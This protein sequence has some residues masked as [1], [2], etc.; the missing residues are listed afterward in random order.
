MTKMRFTRPAMLYETGDA[1]L[2]SAKARMFC[3]K[4]T[5]PLK[6]NGA[7]SDED[8]ALRKVDNS[9]NR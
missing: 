1:T 3:P 9:P 7:A 6:I 2:N 4:C 5:V 8:E